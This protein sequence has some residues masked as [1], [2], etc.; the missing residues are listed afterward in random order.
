MAERISEQVDKVDR[1]RLVEE[2]EDQG[3][4]DQQLGLAAVANTKQSSVPSGVR[5]DFLIKSQVF[6]IVC[7]LPHLQGLCTYGTKCMF[8]HGTNELRSSN[9][10]GGGQPKVFVVFALSFCPFLSFEEDKEK[11]GRRGD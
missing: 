4:G 10:G 11:D 2:G 3:Q 7:H 9:G 1:G 6:S 8:A 5:L